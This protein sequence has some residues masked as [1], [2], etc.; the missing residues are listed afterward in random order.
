MAKD[1]K[2]K[3]PA[4]V[5]RLRRGEPESE[6]EVARSGSLKERELYVKG[7]RDEHRERDAVRRTG[8]KG[9]A[10]R[11]PLRIKP[12]VGFTQVEPG[13]L[14]G[15]DDVIASANALIERLGHDRLEEIRKKPMSKGFLP[16]ADLE[17]ESAYL[18][19]AL[20]DDVLAVVSGYLGLLPVLTYIDV[21]YSC[22]VDGAPYSSQL[23][24]LDHADVT[25][26]KVFLQ[27][28]DVGLSS[29]PLT[30][31][32]ATTSRRLAKQVRYTFRQSRLD[33]DAV[34]GAVGRDAATPLD[35][36]KGTAAFVDTSR[37]FHLGS[38]VDAGAPPRKLV[39]FQYLTPHAF[40]FQCDHRLEGPFRGLATDASPER[41]RLIL[42]AD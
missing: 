35:G 18:R 40:A 1:P 42:G 21:W 13:T 2:R 5:G 26:V 15:A 19:F 3:G 39:L 38:R 4:G 36:P 33:D 8:A 10:R 24:H 34:A 9:L 27:C 28:D 14:P 25:Q 30:V 17:L 16:A 31:L 32:D 6:H 29:G 20:S 7:R 11:A 37:C 41:E 22:H 23:W 12:S